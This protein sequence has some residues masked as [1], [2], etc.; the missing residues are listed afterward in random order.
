MVEK[1]NVIKEKVKH[2]GLGDFKGAYKYAREWLQK[3]NFEVT[4]DSYSEKVSGNAKEIEIEWTANR[5]LTDYY[6]AVL[7]FKWRVLGLVDV[8]VEVDGKR[9]TMNKFV[10]LS[11]EVKGVLEKDYDSKW[12]NSSMQKFFK[13]VYNKYVVIE[14][15]RQKED[16]VRGAVID[17]KEEMKAFLELTG[18]IS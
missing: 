2:S 9:K 4:E 3:E 6:K 15:T 10:E 13:D 17:F 1:D 8:E 12:E 7:K 5:K 16:Q 11:I 14:R 18:R